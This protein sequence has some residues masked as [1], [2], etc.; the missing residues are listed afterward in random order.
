M[1]RATS[2]VAVEDTLPK[3]S[4]TPTRLAAIDVD[5]CT[6]A[7]ISTVRIRLNTIDVDAEEEAVAEP[8]ISI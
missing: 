7:A 5:A 3:T 4:A 2:A 8:L 6:L 1:I